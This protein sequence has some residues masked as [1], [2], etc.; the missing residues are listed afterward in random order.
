LQYSESKAKNRQINA[1]RTSHPSRMFCA[2]LARV[3]TA[4]AVRRTSRNR[5]RG[6]RPFLGALYKSCTHRPRVRVPCLAVIA[7]ADGSVLPM[8]RTF[9]GGRNPRYPRT[10]HDASFGNP[11]AVHPREPPETPVLPQSDSAQDISRLHWRYS[12]GITERPQQK[13]QTWLCTSCAGQVFLV[14]SAG[15]SSAQV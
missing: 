9:P 12:A 4:E 1:A 11:P 15:N 8:R 3:L 10:R 13:I 7:Q 14:E 5:V 2:C 6:E